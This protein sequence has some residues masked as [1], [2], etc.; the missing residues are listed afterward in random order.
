MRLLQYLVMGVHHQETMIF[1]SKGATIKEYI[2]PKEL[3]CKTHDSH[4]KAD[5]RFTGG[6]EGEE[7]L[8]KLKPSTNP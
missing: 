6:K 8:D 7:K 2:I 3:P 4:S 5:L 1:T